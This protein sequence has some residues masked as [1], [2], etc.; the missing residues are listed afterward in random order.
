MLSH[1]E[2]DEQR[3]IAKL[4][5][6]Q[7]EAVYYVHVLGCSEEEAGAQMGCTRGTV[8]GYLRRAHETLRKKLTTT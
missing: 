2:M 5:P 1:F 4:P 6:R 7:V 8:K 3:M